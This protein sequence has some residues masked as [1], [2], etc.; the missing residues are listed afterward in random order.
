MPGLI[1]E[2]NSILPFVFIT[3]LMGGAAGIM[4]GRAVAGTWRPRWLLPL[5]GL[6]LACAIRFIHF[7]LFQGTLLSAHYLAVDYV[8]ILAAVFLGYRRM[9]ARQMS[10]QY[11]WEYRRTG[12][13]TW[14]RRTPPQ[15]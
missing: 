8:C 3:L 15:E 7:A 1:V 9:R 6:L 11:D 14:A 2:T 13:F 12:P 4:T 10:T 5:Y